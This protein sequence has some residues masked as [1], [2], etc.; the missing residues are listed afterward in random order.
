MKP[1]DMDIDEILKRYL[2]R[3]P[4]EEVE[5]AGERVLERIRSMR[6]RSAPAVPDA[7]EQPKAQ[8]LGKF[9]LAVLAAVEQMQGRGRPVTITLKVE[10]LLEERSVSG[11]AVFLV[12][13]F[14]ER[15]G[16]VSSS[17]IDPDDP[18]LDRR[19]FEITAAGRERLTIANAAATRLTDP[20]E[21]FA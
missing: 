10:E 14:L 5:A 4:Q 2:P 6:F 16:L 13:L 20:L 9:H 11:S 21:G 19:Y 17:P 3:A 1:D 12:L 7:A 8:W 18:A 15:M